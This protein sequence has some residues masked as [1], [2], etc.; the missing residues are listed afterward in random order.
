M[1]VGGGGGGGGEGVGGRGYPIVSTAEGRGDALLIKHYTI[2]RIANLLHSDCL[3]VFVEF[4]SLDSWS[5]HCNSLFILSWYLTRGTE[6][7]SGK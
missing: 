6:R 4:C 5:I 2:S 7:S 1:C 3:H